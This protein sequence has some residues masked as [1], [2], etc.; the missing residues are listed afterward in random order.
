MNKREFTR[1]LGEILKQVYALQ[2]VLESCDISTITEDLENLKDETEETIDGI[3]SEEL[4]D[5][6]QERVDA[7]GEVVDR[8]I[9]LEASLNIEEIILDLEAVE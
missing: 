7:I 3:K 8:L 6:W 5:Q 1:S 9:E 2:D 4:R